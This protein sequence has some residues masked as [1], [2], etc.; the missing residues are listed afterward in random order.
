M[1][2]VN[3]TMEAAKESHSRSGKA[4]ARKG[5][6]YVKHLLLRQL[7]LQVHGTW[8]PPHLRAV[9]TR[10]CAAD[11]VGIVL[12]LPQVAWSLSTS[13]RL[14]DPSGILFRGPQGRAVGSAQNRLAP[15]VNTTRDGL[16]SGADVSTC[17]HQYHKAQNQIR[18]RRLHHGQ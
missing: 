10:F 17:W 5:G 16:V 3:H 7:L 9:G 2:A 4:K 8:E 6:S 13:G 1:N 15:V 11:Q 12:E 18:P 14:G